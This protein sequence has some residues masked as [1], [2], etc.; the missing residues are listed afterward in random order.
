MSETT[1]PTRVPFTNGSGDVNLN[2]SRLAVLLGVVIAL[3]AVVG[4]WFVLPHRLTE[5]EKKIQAV[6]IDQRQQREILIR[7]DENVK[8]LKKN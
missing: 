2:L 7:I 6:E 3:I 5:V 8:Q 4:S 1:T